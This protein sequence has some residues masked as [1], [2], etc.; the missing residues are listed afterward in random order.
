MKKILVTGRSSYA[1][2][3]FI[4]RMHEKNQ[5]WIIDAISVRTDDWKT[6][7]FS[8]YDAIYHVAAIVH[9]K[10]KSSR[11]S[12]YFRINSQLPFEI[13]SKAKKEGVKSFVFLSSIAVYGLI[14]EIGK[15][16]V[17]TK[18]TVEKP[19]TLNG[20][21]KLA[22]E[23][24]LKPLQSDEFNVALLRI[25]LIYGRNC[26]GNYSS[27]SKLAKVTP[28]FPTINNER[29][30]VYIDHLSDIVEHVIKLNLNGTFLINNPE[31]FRTMDVVKEIA[32][33]HDKRILESK[34]LG[35]LLN[36]IGNN[37]TVLRKMFGTVH[38]EIEATRI[39]GFK[40]SDIDFS[41]SI[42]ISEGRKSKTI[43]NS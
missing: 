17:I 31:N 9:L 18:K 7:D 38:F 5:H 42:R 37:F 21:S 35:I 27:L 28:I 15:D 32:K 23:Q 19:T 36:S 6:L 25:P 29:S 33:I 30:M 4:K 39:D 1:G 26:P 13:A 11:K 34:I 10:E 12:E 16:L 40:Y 8:V 3:E 22:A 43:Y 41:Q 14:G 24:L 20:K 2:T